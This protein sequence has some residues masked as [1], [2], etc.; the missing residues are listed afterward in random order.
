MFGVV[1]IR[2]LF[3][4]SLQGTTVVLFLEFVCFVFFC[5]F[6]LKLLA[7]LPSAVRVDVFML[8]H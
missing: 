5:C 1:L 3:V 6:N 4:K 8:R 7:A 2:L